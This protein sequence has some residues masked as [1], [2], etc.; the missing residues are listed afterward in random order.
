MF[1]EQLLEYCWKHKLF[2]EEMKTEGG[3]SIEV[4][5]TGLYDRRNLMFFNAKI[6][7]GGTLWVGNVKMLYRSDEWWLHSYDCDSKHQNVVLVVSRE[8]NVAVGR[9][10][11]S[12]IHLLHMHVPERIKRNVMVLMSKEGI[13][14]CHS[15]IKD[16]TSPLACHAWLAAM[17]TESLKEKSSLVSKG[18]LESH[19][20]QSALEGQLF[21]A[22]GLGVNDDI[23]SDIYRSIPMSMT[24]FRWR[25][26][27]SDRQDCSILRRL[28]RTISRM[29]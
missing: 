3:E 28:G 24:S 1:E 14:R 26:S 9:E 10:D 15:C 16:Y 23:M 4:I 18:F 7:I 21:R 2:P 20:W 19:D 12:M 11:G 5:D 13:V 29:H 22:F 27:S 6:R 25:L 8:A 17:Q